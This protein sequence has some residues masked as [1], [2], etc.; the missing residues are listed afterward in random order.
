MDG[1]D[2]PPTATASRTV[3]DDWYQASPT[4]RA[5]VGLVADRPTRRRGR[6]LGLGARRR[7]PEPSAIRSRRAGGGRGLDSSAAML[8]AGG[9]D[10]GH[11]R[12]GACSATWPRRRWATGASPSVRRAQQLFNL[13][14][15]GPASGLAASAAERLA[16]GQV[17]IVSWR[18]S[19]PSAEGPA[20][21]RAPQHRR[22][23]GPSSASPTRRRQAGHRPVADVELEDRHRPPRAW[24]RSGGPT[25]EQ[26]DDLAG[27]PPGVVADAGRTG[28]RSS[29]RRPPRHRT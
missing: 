27:A 16:P 1:Y 28:S 25:P 29:V 7:A 10:G 17:A 22:T 8:A 6:R 15:A 11:A 4:S 2:T 9:E 13:T 3:Y 24:P 12:R 21:G 5:C 14:I 26:L 19:C 20:G 23:G 18:P